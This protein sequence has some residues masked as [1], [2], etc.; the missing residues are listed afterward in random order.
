MSFYTDIIWDLDG[1][2][3]DSS[4]GI[5][6][7]ARFALSHFDIEKENN[8]LKQILGPPLH[9]SFETLFGLTKNDAEKAVKL[10]REYYS[11]KGLF[12]NIPYTGINTL[13]EKLKEDGK[14]LY[15]ATSKPEVFANKILKHFGLSEYFDF[16]A[17][18]L[19]D[20][21][22]SD[23][24]DVIAHVI[25]SSGSIIKKSAIMIGDRK[26][27]IVGAK[28]HNIKS[29]GVL[30]GYGSAEE[31]E[32]FPPTIVVENVDSLKKHLLYSTWQDNI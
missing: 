17:G 11:D 20:N 13:L 23:K 15:L 29:I 6:N 10:F 30:Y 4:P 22:R 28:A 9:K 27:D 21:S 18:S 5:F 12:E 16:T 8:Y 26:H 3:T 19:L 14:R 24:A 31:F 2:V 7:A 25:E 32:Q 1:T